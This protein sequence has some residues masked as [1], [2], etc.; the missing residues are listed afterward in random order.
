MDIKDTVTMQL[1]RFE[2]QADC[3]VSQLA[4]EHNH[5][6]LISQLT[7][8]L[9]ALGMTVK[10]SKTQKILSFTWAGTTILS[11]CKISGKQLQNAWNR[12]DGPH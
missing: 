8:Q 1:D 2:A 10:D 4:I 3:N 9:H 7:D 6:L 5:V 12:K 11:P